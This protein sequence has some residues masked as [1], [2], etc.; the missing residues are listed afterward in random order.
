MS[1]WTRDLLPNTRETVAS[2]LAHGCTFQWR[3]EHSNSYFAAPAETSRIW[4][5]IRKEQR[6]LSFVGPFEWPMVPEQLHALTVV[7][8]HTAQAT[9][10][11]VS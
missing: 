6:L 7:A 9:L 1:Q 10:T 5:E 2:L 4:L 11:D 8:C 3:Q